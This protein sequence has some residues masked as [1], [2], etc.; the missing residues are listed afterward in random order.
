MVE[1]AE[2]QKS[3]VGSQSCPDKAKDIE[4][5]TETGNSP[6]FPVGPCKNHQNILGKIQLSNELIELFFLLAKSKYVRSV[7]FCCESK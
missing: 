5:P 3:T 2:G 4:E 6:C 7:I 1:K